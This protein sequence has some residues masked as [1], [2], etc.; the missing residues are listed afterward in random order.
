MDDPD[1]PFSYHHDVIEASKR[2][3]RGSD[4]LDWYNATTAFSEDKYKG[5]R[6]ADLRKTR[7]GTL[8]VNLF[9]R[10]HTA[11][12]CGTK[13]TRLQDGKSCAVY[14]EPGA[15]LSF[16]I[17][18]GMEIPHFGLHL[19]LQ[20]QN[21]KTLY[22]D[23]TMVWTAW[24]DDDFDS[25]RTPTFTPSDTER[26]TFSASLTDVN[27][28]KVKLDENSAK[29]CNGKDGAE[30]FEI[31]WTSHT[32][33][34]MVSGF[35]I[36]DAQL[37]QLFRPEQIQT[38]QRFRNMR[39]KNISIRVVTRIQRDEILHNWCGMAAMPR[40][41]LPPY[42]FYAC[43]YVKQ[44]KMFTMMKAI[45]PVT[46][47]IIKHHH[48]RR[49]FGW[50]SMTDSGFQET[51]ELLTHTNAPFTVFLNEREYEAIRMIGLLREADAQKETAI[52]QFNNF[53]EFELFRASDVHNVK[54]K[55]LDEYFYGVID[56]KFILRDREDAQEM[57]EQ[58]MPLP[59]PGTPVTISPQRQKGSEEP[60][61]VNKNRLWQGVVVSSQGISSI[62]NRQS[63]YHAVCVRL[64]RPAIQESI[65]MRLNLAGF[66]TF[67]S[68]NPAIVQ[69][70]RA[71][72]YAMWGNDHF[73]VARDNKVKRLL[74]AHDNA[75]IEFHRHGD[76]VDQKT[77]QFINNI[78]RTRNEEQIK[79]IR[80]AFS[81]G[82]LWWNFLSL[83][84]GPP[85]TGKTS[86]SVSIAAHCL[87]R[88]WPL[89]IVCASNHGLDV[90][91]ERIIRLG[92][93]YRES[94]EMQMQMPR[95]SSSY[96]G[97]EDE[98]EDE[99]EDEDDYYRRE[100]S[101]MF[102]KVDR[103]LRERGVDPE[104][105][106]VVISSME[107]ITDPSHR[108]SLGAHITNSL[109]RIM[110]RGQPKQITRDKAASDISVKERD[111]LW[112][113]I[114]FQELL[115]RQGDLFLESTALVLASGSTY[116]DESPPRT[117]HA[118]LVREQ[119]RLWLNLQELYL[120]NAKI[121][122]CTASTAGRKALRGF[123]P[124]YLIV[125]EASQMVESQALNGIMRNLNGLKKVILSG[126]TA[127]LPPTVISRGSNECFNTEQVSLFERM[128]Q[129]GHPH[130]QLRTQ[131]RMAPDICKHVSE[132]F[133]DS[134]LTTHQSC[135]NRPK[136]KDFSTK[137]AGWYDCR[138]GTSYF[139]SVDKSSLWRRKGSTSV[140]NPEYVDFIC[141]LVSQMIR[142]GIPQDEIL[143]LSFY[144]EERRA[145]SSLLH[146]NLQ[147][148]A[149]EV[150]SV[151][152]SQGSESPFVI[153]ST[154]RPGGQT[155]IGFVRDRNRQ[156]VALSR[157][158]DGLVIVGHENMAKGHEGHGYDSWRKVIRDHDTAGRLIRRVGNRTKVVG[159]L[160]ISEKDWEQLH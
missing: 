30:A 152:A 93:D 97:D 145:L 139:V 80:S 113:F 147:L 85:G 28:K 106:Q 118:K 54:G 90:I 123:R 141:G 96:A 82:S 60:R 91:T 134:K 51:P 115:R 150:K 49:K 102:R 125:E 50:P 158:Q 109:E 48:R 40:P 61:K 41:T 107:G 31:Q 59:Q 18:G 33:P 74:L 87:E 4:E 117:S 140:L 132:S 108:F 89:L 1:E 65:G 73:A 10:F 58:A 78:Q 44:A 128:I 57:L 138:R 34:Q 126:D 92:T 142:G 39:A 21:S 45:P 23:F 104:L 124:S 25:E 94:H 121:V 8:T 38:F 119:K 130:T 129:T 143:I 100:P 27:L 77:G 155:G 146:D 55:G 16:F 70:R 24:D 52:T 114:T 71:I 120:K 151:D 76:L 137:M 17:G 101:L 53:Y 79:A 46:D 19:R 83:V 103:D 64:K 84:T 154:T 157:A 105:R 111:C 32:I 160:A 2:M 20:V 86:V 15:L 68:P 47:P 116:A 98:N 156:C 159:K 144:D 95:E 131:Y 6:P 56:A 75:N 69:A 63:S 112:D 135:F 88:K 37:E 153:L 42:P 81:D 127:Q 11:I 36:P 122:L 66:A 3:T 14:S 13:A 22:R 99:N 35:E 43:R 9:Q 62:V 149:I 67:G 12:V 29:A 133:Y 136:A 72:R 5:K 26:F 110:A 148:R 7:A